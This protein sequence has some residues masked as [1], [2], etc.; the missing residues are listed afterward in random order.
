LLDPDDT[1]LRYNLACAMVRAGEPTYALDRLE[2]TLAKSG[3]SMLIWA[4]TDNDLDLLRENPRFKAIMAEAEARFGV[5]AVG[6]AP[7]P[8]G[9]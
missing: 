1:T 7:A 9:A 5:A 4:Q 8:T 3:R 2:E 6:E